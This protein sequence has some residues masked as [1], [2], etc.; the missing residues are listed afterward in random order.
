M[1]NFSGRAEE[2]DEYKQFMPDVEL[3]AAKVN[4]PTMEELKIK[5]LPKFKS[6]KLP[7]AK[8]FRDLDDPVS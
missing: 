6:I 8:G 5:K 2:W 1:F 7:K 4:V 3:C